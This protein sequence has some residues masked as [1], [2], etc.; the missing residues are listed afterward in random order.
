VAALS[1]RYG[2]AHAADCSGTLMPIT[3]IGAVPNRRVWRPSLPGSW[4]ILGQLTLVPSASLAGTR[5]WMHAG[6]T[7]GT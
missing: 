4:Q 6:P 5:V 3:P 7:G 1:D 2:I